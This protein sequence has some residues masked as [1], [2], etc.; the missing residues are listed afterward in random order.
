[1]RS[2]WRPLLAATF[3]LGTGSAAITLYTASVI[4]PHMI[5][6]L[7]WSKAQFALLGTLSILH[8]F[9]FPIAGRLADLYGVKRTALIGIVVLPLSLVAFSLMTGPIWQY[10]G[11]HV[12]ASILCITTTNTIYS[13]I[14]VQHVERARGLALAI[15]ASGPALTGAI[16]SPLVNG[17][18][19]AQGWRTAYHVLALYAAVTGVVTLLLLPRK[20]RPSSEL[21]GRKKRR[22]RDDYPRIFRTPAFWILLVVMLLC[23]LPQIVAMTQLKMVLMENGISAKGTSVMLAALPVGVL[24]GRFVAGF[25]LDRFAPHIVGFFG[26][27]LPSVGLLLFATGLDAPLVLTFAVLCIGFA[28]GAEGDILAFVVARKFGVAIYSSVMGML[29]MAIS[30]SVALGAALLSLTLKLTGGYNA[31]MLICAAAVFGGSLLML[32]LSN[33]QAQEPEPQA[34]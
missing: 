34:A 12:V 2:N 1:M 26:L 19:E 7:G 8:L 6:D 24:V 17:L 27:S 3:G 32:L 23:N 21:E 20:K 31:Y 16:V 15:V 29:T 5:A 10:I 30:L 14:A 25:A 9:A 28:V 11:I 13:R 33:P 22:A 18:V 4:A